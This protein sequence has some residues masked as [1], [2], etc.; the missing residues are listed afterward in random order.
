MGGGLIQLKF[1]GKE[2]DFFIGNP[3]ISF[4]RSVFKSYSN[5]SKELIDILKESSS[6]VKHKL[7]KGDE[8]TDLDILWATGP[9]VVTT[10]VDEFK[11]KS[12]MLIESGTIKHDAHGSWRK[13][14]DL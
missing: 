6:R 13:D 2:A 14:E 5:Y 10:I 8:W 3:Q 11:D 4:F 1:L 12:S 7:D 9:D